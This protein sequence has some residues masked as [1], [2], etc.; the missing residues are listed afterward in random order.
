MQFDIGIMRA[1]QSLHGLMGSA[2]D[3]IFAAFTFLGE[4]TFIILLLAG[5]YWCANKRMGEYL[6]LSLYTSTAF[7]VFAK[8]LIKRPRPFMGENAGLFRYVKIDNPLVDTVSLSHS[9]SFPS[10]HSQSA[11]SVFGGLALWFKKP[12]VTA[13]CAL[14]TLGVMVSRVY[15]GVHYPTDVLTGA[16]LG[17]AF[18]A[19]LY[20]VFERF[21]HHRAPVFAIAVFLS[22]LTLLGDFSADAVKALGLGIGA[23]LGVFLE[24]KTLKFETDGTL[25]RRITRLLLGV[26]LIA[27]IKLGA[28]TLLPD[29]DI[30]SALS[31]AL[32]GFFIIYIWP[33]IFTKLK[34]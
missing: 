22:S 16:V 20:H 18:S 28:G 34:I 3:V 27:G 1:I 23:A 13:A 5:I 15:L 7:N 25:P 6:I 10:G 29:G 33:L 21:Y 8:D 31:Y 30:F 14:L 2:G 19:L 24:E 26:A 4:E 11:A 9:Y 17:F 12:G 32:L